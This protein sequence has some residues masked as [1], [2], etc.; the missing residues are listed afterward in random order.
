LCVSISFGKDFNMNHLS[1]SRQAV[2]ESFSLIWCNKRLL[3]YLFF[4]LCLS[5]GPLL[6][7]RYIS[8]LLASMPFFK[9]VM[10]GSV[11]LLHAIP[12][13]V[14][15]LI[16]SILSAALFSRVYALL[17]NKKMSFI[18]SFSFDRGLLS[19]IILWAFIIVVVQ[20]AQA[21][22]IAQGRGIYY[23][24]IVG[25]GGT[26]KYKSFFM[27][28]L[29]LIIFFMC[30]IVFFMWPVCAYYILPILVKKNKGFW[31]TVKE[32]FQLGWKY[33]WVTL[34]SWLMVFSLVGLF[35][36]ALAIPIIIILGLYGIPISGTPI[37]L[38]WLMRALFS[39]PFAVMRYGI[40]VVLVGMPLLLLGLYVATVSNV[41][42]AVIY[43]KLMKLR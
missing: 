11:S 23:S 36:I 18:E 16:V 30:F 22:F 20:L 2:K 42:P 41:L 43:N 5:I 19:K 29:S 4:C 28:V 7:N 3:W 37:L 34:L 33:I 27:W 25:V 15:S 9:S 12:L 21:F 6:L 39:D 40:L 14:S 24:L 8:V 31:Q 17:S 13:F 26:I 1:I 32:G 10:F 38:I 35:I